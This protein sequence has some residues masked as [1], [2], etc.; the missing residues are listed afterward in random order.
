VR[1]RYIVAYDVSDAKRLRQT[2]KKM[3]GFGDPLQYSVFSCDL[4][5]VELTLMK[6]AIGAIINHSEDRV[7]IVDIGPVEGRAVVAFDFLGVKLRVPAGT[8]SVIV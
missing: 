1:H 2:Y 6:R 7:M 4:S 5:D 3:N 8:E